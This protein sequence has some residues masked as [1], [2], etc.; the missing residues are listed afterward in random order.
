M[1]S[2]IAV[3]VDGCPGGWL[4]V[5]EGT[6]R[7]LIATIAQTFAALIEL[8]PSTAVIGLDIPI[9]LPEEGARQCEKEARQ[10]LGWPRMTSVF[11]APL[12]PCLVARSYEEACRIRSEIERKKI[13][14]QAFGILPKIREVDDVLATNRALA[15]RVIE[16]HPEVSFAIMNG[17]AAL[18]YSKKKRDGKAVR[19]ALLEAQWPGSVDKLRDRL[20]GQDCAI[21]DLH[22]AMA[23]L[24]SARRSVS[25]K[26]RVLGDPA[27]R[28]R[29]GL[30]M[31][32]VG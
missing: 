27:A 14:K 10:L 32:I 3:G 21:D 24:W 28:D 8:L 15:A 12:R 30:L 29:K 7:T 6:S 4:A 31:R 11:S 23:A 19:R 18:V 1:R 26:A 17:G 22:D 2:R 25:G 16:V 5:S 9:G 13:S 20:R